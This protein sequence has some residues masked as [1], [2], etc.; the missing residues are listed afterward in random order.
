MQTSKSL[1]GQQSHREVATY[2]TSTAHS[3]SSSKGRPASIA[4]SCV[5]ACLDT[6][7]EECKPE[8]RKVTTQVGK[9]HVSRMQNPASGDKHSRGTTTLARLIAFNVKAPRLLGA[10]G[11]NLVVFSSNTASC[12]IPRTALWGRK[13][14]ARHA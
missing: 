1:A 11:G 13:V 6:P 2:F 5:R 10:C 9:K 3:S 12:M 7:Q 14:W 8:M 4:S